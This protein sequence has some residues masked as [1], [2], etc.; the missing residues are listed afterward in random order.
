MDAMKLWIDPEGR[1]A[2]A[3]NVE[4][5]TRWLGTLAVRLMPT[6]NGFRAAAHPESCEPSGPRLCKDHPAGETHY[7]PIETK[8]LMCGHRRDARDMSNR[9]CDVCQVISEALREKVTS[10]PVRVCFKCAYW[11][12]TMSTALDGE[13]HRYP[14][15]VGKV[16]SSTCGEF[17]ARS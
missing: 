15:K 7:Q 4:E 8:A 11:S 13:C 2:F 6:V 5:A 9:R 17:K 16:G 10:V 1:F 12:G 3:R 14:Q